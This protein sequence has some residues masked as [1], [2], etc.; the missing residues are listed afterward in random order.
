VDAPAITCH[1]RRRATL[2]TDP[3]G[4]ACFPSA[5]SATMPF[6]GLSA[7]DAT[8]VLRG[9]PHGRPGFRASG[10]RLIWPAMTPGGRLR[11]GKASKWARHALSAGHERHWFTVY[12][13]ISGS[14]YSSQSSHSSRQ[15]A[16]SSRGIEESAAS[17]DS[18]LFVTMS[19][20]T[21]ETSE[22]APGGRCGSA[23]R[24]GRG[25]DRSGVPAPCVPLAYRGRR[26]R[27]CR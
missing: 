23:R 9:R 24:G 21:C 26:W 7:H 27:S 19:S 12:S 14:S 22:L 10:G 18:K 11:L 5:L 17:S 8:S 3:L 16:P 15:S 20:L 2:D 13:V 4:G 25:R 6:V 1:G